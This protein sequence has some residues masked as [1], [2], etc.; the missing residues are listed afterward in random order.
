MSIGQHETHE[1]GSQG[2]HPDLIQADASA[3]WALVS[4][5]G[6][7]ALAEALRGVTLVASPSTWSDDRFWLASAGDVDR[8]QFIAVGNA[9]N[10]RFWSHSADGVHSMS[11]VLAGE[12]FVG[13][14]Y[15]WRRMRM[16]VE[17]DEYP[18]LS[19]QHLTRITIDGFREL[20]SDDFGDNPLREGISDR[21][22]NLVDLGEKLTRHWGGEFSNLVQASRGSLDSFFAHSAR[23]R[24]YDDP[25][26]KLTSVNAIMLSGAGLASFDSEIPP[27]TDY[28]I[29]K[30]LLRFGAVDV[31]PITYEDLVQSK[32]L[33]PA[34]AMTIRKVCL[35]AIVEA[36]KLGKLSGALVDNILWQNRRV[37]LEPVPN[38][39]ECG[40]FS[41]C[42][43]RVE[44]QRPLETTRYY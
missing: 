5:A 17:R 40:L 13:S 34:V 2:H 28:H 33:A 38:C 7:A 27:A 43:R 39:G 25:L 9:L 18:I 41:A 36:C 1:R 35:V 21:V 30:Q 6:V 10:F 24:A 42:G 23:F 37:C 8:R 11:G 31:D 26:G 14:M 32:L 4:D 20:F 12:R 15:M 44:M 22:C 3:R 16:L 29:V 19:A